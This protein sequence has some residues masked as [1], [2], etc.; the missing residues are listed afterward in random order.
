MVNQKHP[1]LKQF[2]VDSLTRSRVKSCNSCR[3]RKRKCSRKYPICSYCQKHGLECLYS[4]KSRASEDFK[5]QEQAE[6]LLGLSSQAHKMTSLATKPLISMP[7]EFT[8]LQSEEIVDQ[9][10]GRAAEKVIERENISPPSVSGDS[11]SS[12]TYSSGSKNFSTSTLASSVWGDARS[13]KVLNQAD[14]VPPERQMTQPPEFHNTDYVQKISQVGGVVD[15]K[16]RLTCRNHVYTALRPEQSDILDTLPVSKFF[17]PYQIQDDQLHRFKVDPNVRVGPI[18]TKI[19][20][21]SL[22]TTG[23]SLNKDLT[24]LSSYVP[25]RK[26]ADTLFARYVNSVHPIMPLLD[27]R[28]F[29]LQ[30]EMLW[31]NRASTPLSFYILL[32]AVLYAGSVSEFEELSVTKNST[33]TNQECVDHM[34]HLVGATEIALAISDFPAKVTLVGLQASVILHSV[35]RNDCRTDDCGSVATLVRLAQLIE[36]NRDPQD[37]H[38][39][40]EHQ[41]IQERR[42]LWWHIYFLD[43]ST[44]LSSRI[45]PMIVDGEF[46]TN[47]PSEYYKEQTGIYRMDQGIAFANGRFRWSETCNKISRHAFSLKGFSQPVIDH[48][49]QDIENLGLHC[50]SSILRILDSTNVMPNQENFVAFSSSMLSTFRDRCYCLLNMIL[51]TS[52]RLP[53]TSSTA[54]ILINHLGDS[55]VRSMLHLLLEFCKHGAMPQNV[56]FVWE[57]RKYQPI[58]VFFFLLRNLIADIKKIED[59]SGVRA[60]KEDERVLSIE[61]AMNVLGYLSEH[62]TKLC[63]ERWELLRDL[64]N[65]T[66]D[67][68]FKSRCIFSLNS[69]TPKHF[70]PNSELPDTFSEDWDAIIQKLTSIENTIDDNIFAKNWDELSGHYVT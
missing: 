9:Q 41:S 55:L 10:T 23:Q 8:L 36:L 70:T 14:I 11:T 48:I 30:Y 61:R 13:G 67:Q 24:L 33:Y 54:D 28:A 38:R 19:F 51:S 59:D 66:W 58:Q 49:I 5:L 60:L 31:N 50:T 1:G 68:I 26:V 20:N 22:T 29:Y 3:E 64:K 42:L 57:I 43:C 21:S 6:I 52:N 40:T 27:I 63:E 53:E 45:P 17:W 65:T 7:Q 16:G 12:T 56:I 44:S 39:I 15:T 46:D 35:I 34:K 37:Y 62:T 2:T 32:F 4:Q 69:S 25:S 18:Y 47:L